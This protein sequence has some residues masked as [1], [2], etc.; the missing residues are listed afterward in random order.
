[1][2]AD[3]S[4]DSVAREVGT[5]GRLGGQAFV[6]GVA[7]VWK[8]LTDNVNVMAANLTL[9]VRTIAVATVCR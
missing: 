8:D 7:G 2:E 3:G 9:Q 5:L 1:M 4:L 6:P